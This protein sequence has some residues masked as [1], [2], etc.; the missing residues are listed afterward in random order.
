VYY[1]LTLLSL[2]SRVYI[3]INKQDKTTPEYPLFDTYPFCV[4]M[5]WRRQ[6]TLSVQQK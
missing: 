1:F 2:L 4:L 6:Q 3:E 5:V